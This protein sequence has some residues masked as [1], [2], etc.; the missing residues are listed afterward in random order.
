MGTDHVFLIY[1]T[2]TIP[3]HR[4]IHAGHTLAHQPARQQ[5]RMACF[6][7]NSDYQYFLETLAEQAAKSKCCL[8]AWCLIIISIR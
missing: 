1:L 3:N 5:Q 4:L 2:G 8:Y 6:Y 7:E